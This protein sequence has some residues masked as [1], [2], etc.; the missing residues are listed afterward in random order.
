M[1]PN[2]GDR[3]SLRRRTGAP[4]DD[5]LAESDAFRRRARAAARR[6]SRSDGAASRD[7]R[8][9]V[10][11]SLRWYESAVCKLAHGRRR[12]PLAVRA[13]DDRAAGWPRDWLVFLRAAEVRK[14]HPP[15]RLPALVPIR[16]KQRQLR[17]VR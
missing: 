7:G 13:D 6:S 11:I 14:L 4:T 16:A 8:A 12:G 5:G 3:Q 9:R 17:R 15:A 1:G 10:S 2:L